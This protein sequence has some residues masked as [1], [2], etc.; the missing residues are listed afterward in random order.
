[1]YSMKITHNHIY[2]IYSDY[3]Y[4]Q[5]CNPLRVVQSEIERQVWNGTIIA[6]R[7]K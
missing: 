1:M 2:T 7:V 3:I 6:T 5:E 4:T